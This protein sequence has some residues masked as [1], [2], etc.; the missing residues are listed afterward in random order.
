MFDYPLRNGF[1]T[2]TALSSDNST[3][4]IIDKRV[5]LASQR[6]DSQNKG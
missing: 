5:R 3:L 1:E 6:R 2:R 4:S